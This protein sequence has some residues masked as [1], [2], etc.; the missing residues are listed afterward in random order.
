MAID[1]KNILII[2]LVFIPPYLGVL[3]SLLATKTKE[4][5]FNYSISYLAGHNK[6]TGDLFNLMTCLFGVLSA[7]LPLNLILIYKGNLY[8]VIL[9][10]FYLLSLIFTF[11]VGA[12]PVQRHQKRHNFLAKLM[13]G[14]S[15]FTLLGFCFLW[16]FLN[17][18][19]YVSIFSFTILLCNYKL[20]KSSYRSKFSPMWEWISV[21]GLIFWS[22][23][24]ALTILST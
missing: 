11:A 17:N 2:F 4:N 20:I 19:I 16:I 1:L 7:V 14:M 18:F 13:F 12:V 5:I 23:F 6:R 24:L 9:S 3:L 10:S 15:F 21:I 8:L 22:L